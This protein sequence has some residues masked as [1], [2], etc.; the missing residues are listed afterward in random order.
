MFKQDLFAQFAR[1]GKA[2]SNGNR[3]ELLEFLA[4]AERSVDELAK[5]AGLSVANTSQHLQ[6]LR[7]VGLVSSS[8]RGLKVYYQISGD[9]VVDLLNRLRQVSEQHL[10]DVNQL[11]DTYLTVKDELEPVPR[12]E[13]MARVRQ[14][15]VTV[16]DVRPA[17]EFAAGHVPGAI[18]V[19]P[20]E[21]EQ[22]LK[23]LDSAQEVV[24]YCRGAHCILSFDAVEKLREQGVK[25]SRLEEGFPEW[26][27]AGYPVELSA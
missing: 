4:Q 5:L 21:L 27:S 12:D 24:A 26:K 7:Q 25:A 3:L 18:N 19:P 13:L 2:L 17:E 8:K 11:V 1:V 22:R 10:A 15:L 20:D 16:I 14:G 23:S 9:D 6:Q